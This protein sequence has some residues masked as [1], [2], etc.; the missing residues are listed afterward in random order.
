MTRNYLVILSP[1]C[2]TNF[3]SLMV[4]AEEDMVAGEISRGLPNK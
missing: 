1:Q 3:V 2:K 4:V